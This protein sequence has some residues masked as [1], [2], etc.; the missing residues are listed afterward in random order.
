MARRGRRSGFRMTCSMDSWRVV[1]QLPD[2]SWVD[3][4]TLRASMVLQDQQD[5]VWRKR[6]DKE[7]LFRSSVCV[8]VEV[9]MRGMLSTD[10]VH[11]IG[12]EQRLMDM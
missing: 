11:V 4:N 2:D 10:R 8:I 9:R 5:G 7:V 12:A 3:G 1:N 6:R